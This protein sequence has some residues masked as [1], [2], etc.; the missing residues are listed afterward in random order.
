M[1]HYERT[2]RV[3]QTPPPICPKCGSHRTEIVERL[4]NGETGVVRCNACGERSRIP[5]P[6]DEARSGNA[7]TNE[8][9]A[10]R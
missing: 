2:L 8:S 5:L 9:S 10:S 1:V 6:I 4:P 7:A 3:A